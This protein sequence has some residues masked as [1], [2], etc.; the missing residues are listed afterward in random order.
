[1][2]DYNELFNIYGERSLSLS[3]YYHSLM[4]DVHKL[5]NNPMQFQTNIYFVCS[6]L[7]KNP[8]Y[9]LYIS[10][11]IKKGFNSHGIYPHSN[12]INYIMSI[13]NKTPID[14]I[15]YLYIV[16][17]VVL[18][19]YC[20]IVNPTKTYDNISLVFNIV[21][22]DDSTVQYVIK[23][24]NITIN[25]KRDKTIIHFLKNACNYCSTYNKLLPCCSK[26]KHVRYC[27]KHCQKKDWKLHKTICN[28]S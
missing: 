13:I 9:D 16:N 5:S 26:C 14:N 20:P 23:D 22:L 17:F 21:S 11:R 10:Y 6:F 28:I 12:I 7:C 3:K 19:N 4:L 15:C 24:H 8:T 25:Y 1:M 2:N 27:S 18:I